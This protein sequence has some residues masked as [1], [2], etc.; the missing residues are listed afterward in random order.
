MKYAPI[1]GIKI[2]YEIH[3]KGKPLFLVHGYAGI[4]ENWFCLIPLLKKSYKVIV[5]DLRSTGDS[6]HPNRPITM[7]NFS[8][9]LKGLMG[10]L[11]IE[12]AHIGGA[13]MGGMIA[14]Q[15]ASSYPES[16]DKLIL[17]NT[18]YNG[19]M[20]EIILESSLNSFENTKNHPEKAFWEGTAF[21]Y[22]SS[23]RRALKKDPKKKVNGLVSAEDLINLIRKDQNSKEDLINHAHAFKG[24]DL[25]DSLNAIKIPTLLLA[26]SN[27]RILPNSQM[28]EME[29]LIP[30]SKLIVIPKTGHGS[31]REKPQLV[32][33]A[34]LKFLEE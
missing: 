2:C 33:N 21:L 28:L 22:H 6:S 9:D 10:Y 17:I 3:G 31:Y 32:A 30:N 29:K 8:D 14:Q 15:F 27:D 5:F 16:V 11:N 13:S 23:F 26:A 12:R 34:I 25:H 1:N 4:K 24:F 7:K 18:H 20:G 19:V